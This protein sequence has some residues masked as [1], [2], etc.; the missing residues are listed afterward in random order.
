[1]HQDSKLPC[2]VSLTSTR[3]HGPLPSHVEQLKHE[4]EVSPAMWPCGA[5]LMWTR[6]CPLAIVPSCS[7]GPALDRCSQLPWGG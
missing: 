1:M 6:P 5:G 4:S 2:R 7:S 3:P